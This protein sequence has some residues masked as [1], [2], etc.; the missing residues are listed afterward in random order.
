MPV[1][2][3]TIPEDLRKK[4]DDAHRVLL[5]VH[6]ALIDH[7]RIAYESQHGSVGTPLKFLEIVMHDPSFAWLR[8]ISTLIVEIDEFVSTRQP[9][10]NKEGEALLVEAKQLLVPSADGND[11]QLRYHAAV[12]SSSDV[13]AAHAE[14]KTVSK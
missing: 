12:H 7:E 6:K 2:H 5:R 3:S 4:L 10:E 13:A 1:R 9:R 14:W 11:F 8:P